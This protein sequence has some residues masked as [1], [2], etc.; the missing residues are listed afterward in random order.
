[1][2]MVATARALDLAKL[3]CDQLIWA[4]TVLVHVGFTVDA[5][6]REV[7]AAYDATIISTN[8]AAI[9]ATLSLPS[10]HWRPREPRCFSC[11]MRVM[12]AVRGGVYIGEVGYK[13]RL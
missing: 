1:M 8:T 3:L 5:M 12:V 2:R 13:S 9:K 7:S 6:L 4:E 10:S 11:V